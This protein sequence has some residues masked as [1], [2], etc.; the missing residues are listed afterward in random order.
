MVNSFSKEEQTD[1]LN[2]E[3]KEIKNFKTL[4]NVILKNNPNPLPDKCDCP[5]IVQVKE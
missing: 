4:K 5:R 1:F 3:N 2:S